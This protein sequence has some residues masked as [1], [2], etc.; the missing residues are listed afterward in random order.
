ME[1]PGDE[2]LGETRRHV[3]MQPGTLR[4]ASTTPDNI[5]ILPGMSAA[6]SCRVLAHEIGHALID[7]VEW[8]V[9]PIVA[10]IFGDPVQECAVESASALVMGELR[11]TDGQF[12]AQFL[13]MQSG[14][15]EEMITAVRPLAVDLAGQILAGIGALTTA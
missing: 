9:P 8:P 6:S 13:A 4:Y 1:A 7:P 2:A 14:G 12:S 11:A 5:A 10:L 15:D 3:S